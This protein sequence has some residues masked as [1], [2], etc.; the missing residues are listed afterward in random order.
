MP[1]TCSECPC[2]INLWLMVPQKHK[3]LTALTRAFKKGAE[4]SGGLNQVTA[5]II[6]RW[7]AAVVSGTL[8]DG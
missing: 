5:Q 4:E 3:A 6:C 2:V 7:R 1:P 8:S